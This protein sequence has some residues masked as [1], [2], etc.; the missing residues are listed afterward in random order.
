MNSLPEQ[1]DFIGAGFK[2]VEHFKKDPPMIKWGMVYRNKMDDGE[3]IKYLEK[4]AS[5]MNHA[6]D[7]I[8]KERD[9]LMEI[10]E[11]KEEQIKSLDK[12]LQQNNTMIQGEINRANQK[13]QESNRIIAGLNQKIRELEGG[14]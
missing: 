14:N 8:Q 13:Q 2:E 4:L 10:C 5:A 7:L 11:K 6:A 9:E 12:S 3:K 1:S